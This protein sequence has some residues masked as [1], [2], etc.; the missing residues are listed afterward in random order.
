MS[1]SE[2]TTEL[3]TWKGVYDFAVDGGAVSTIPLRSNDGQIPNG[4][5]VLGGWLEVETGFTTGASATGAIQVEAANDTVNATSVAGA[6]FSTT[7]RKSIIPVFTGATT[8]KTTAARSPSLVIGTGAVTA[9]KCNL[10]L[11]YR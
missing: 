11:V 1:V 10:V 4:S 5:I 8:L 3:K 6:P 7:G 9:G 2:G